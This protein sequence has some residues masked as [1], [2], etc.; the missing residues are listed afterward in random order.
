MHEHRKS[1]I[2]CKFVIFITLMLSWKDLKFSVNNNLI[3]FC[4]DLLSPIHFSMSVSLGFLYE[5][6]PK[7]TSIEISFRWNS[8]AF[9]GL[10]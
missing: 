7:D 8:L 9:G 10:K 6:P 5:Y 4:L 3:S 1:V 2:F